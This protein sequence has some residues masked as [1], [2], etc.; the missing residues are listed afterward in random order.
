MHELHT[1]VQQVLLY[2]CAPRIAVNWLVLIRSVNHQAALEIAI[3]TRLWYALLQTTFAKAT[4]LSTAVKLADDENNQ[5]RSAQV[6][7]KIFF[8]GMQAVMFLSRIPTS[9]HTSAA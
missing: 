1:L 9:C 5:S 8:F 7:H 2:Q 6:P 3:Q 4:Q